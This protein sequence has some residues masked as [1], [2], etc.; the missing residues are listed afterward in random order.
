VQEY[1]IS[2]YGNVQNVYVCDRKPGYMQLMNKS[3]NNLFENCHIYIAIISLNSCKIAIK[4]Y[5]CTNVCLSVAQSLL[6]NF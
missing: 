5:Y 4:N 3:A 6:F 1:C 2:V